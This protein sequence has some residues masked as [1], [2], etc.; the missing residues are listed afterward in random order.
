MSAGTAARLDYSSVLRDPEKR[1]LEVS[2]CGG[3]IACLLRAQSLTR[4]PANPQ[5]IR[6]LIQQQRYLELLEAR[7]VQK[8]LAILRDRLTPLHHATERLHQLSR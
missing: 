6:F 1:P 7:H 2:V 3:P 4:R 5:S 8:A